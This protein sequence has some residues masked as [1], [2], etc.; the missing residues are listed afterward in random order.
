MRFPIFFYNAYLFNPLANTVVV[1]SVRTRRM[2]DLSRR[3]EALPFPFQQPLDR[4]IK[5]PRQLLKQP[6]VPIVGQVMALSDQMKICEI[7]S[8]F[9]L[10]ITLVSGETVTNKYKTRISDSDD[11]IVVIHGE[12]A[13]AFNPSVVFPANVGK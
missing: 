8:Q 11:V 6:R 2:Q 13:I 3:I 7:R 1:L 5:N 10:Q 4:P 9:S 12:R